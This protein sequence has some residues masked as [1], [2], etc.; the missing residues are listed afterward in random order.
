LL[1][2]TGPSIRLQASG[3]VLLGYT[4]PSILQHRASSFW[5]RIARKYRPQHSATKGS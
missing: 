4:G 5:Y 3:I 1:G 2:Y